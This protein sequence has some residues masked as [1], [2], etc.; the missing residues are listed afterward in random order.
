[1]ICS[2]RL[3]PDVDEIT[4]EAAPSHPS[5]CTEEW[6]QKDV[7]SG[8]NYLLSEQQ[9]EVVGCIAYKVTGTSTL[10]AQRLAVVPAY[11]GGSFV[12]ELNGTS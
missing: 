2:K 6:I 5:Q 12:G 8:W 10:E 9:R 1:V 11:R 3:Q 7:N 4:A